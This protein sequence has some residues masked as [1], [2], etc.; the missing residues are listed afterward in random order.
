MGKK[1]KKKGGEEWE[2]KDGNGTRLRLPVLY[3]SLIVSDIW[4]IE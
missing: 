1:G 3:M 2:S 4:P